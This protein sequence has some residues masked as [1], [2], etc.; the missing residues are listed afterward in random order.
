[1]SSGRHLSRGTLPSTLR[2][3]KAYASPAAALS[4]RVLPRLAK[5]VAY[6][7]IVLNVR[8][9]PFAW[10][11]MPPPPYFDNPTLMFSLFS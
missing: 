6:I 7:L 10:H 3:V 1:M 5:L 9:L 4:L 2:L 11:S 8:S